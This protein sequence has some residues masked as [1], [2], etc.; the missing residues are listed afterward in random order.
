MNMERFNPET[1]INTQAEK[2]LRKEAVRI[3][4]NDPLSSSTETPKSIDQ[5]P[6]ETWVDSLNPD[7]IQLR[8][9]SQLGRSSLGGFELELIKIYGVDSNNSLEHKHKLRDAWL[10]AISEGVEQIE[11][12]IT[13]KNQERAD[14]LTQEFLINFPTYSNLPS[15]LEHLKTGAISDRDL[16]EATEL[17]Q[18]NLAHIEQKFR[19]YA[20]IIKTKFSNAVA[21]AVES[22]ILPRQAN[23]NLSRIENVTVQIIDRIEKSGSK[24]VGASTHD[25]TIGAQSSYIYTFDENKPN[26]ELDSTIFHELVHTIAG[27][28]LQRINTPSALSRKLAV[29]FKRVKTGVDINEQNLWLNEALTQY[30]AQIL[31]NISQGAPDTSIDQLLDDEDSYAR[32]QLKLH[33]LI[34][35]GVSLETLLNAYFENF[36]PADK[37]FEGHPPAL[38]VLKKEIENIEG[39]DSMMRFNNMFTFN[40]IYSNIVYPTGK[41]NHIFLLQDSI[42]KADVRLS[43]WLGLRGDGLKFIRVDV[44]IGETANEAATESFLYV[45]DTDTDKFDIDKAIADTKTDIEESLNQYKPKNHAKKLTYSIKTHLSDDPSD[46]N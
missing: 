8:R 39:A 2:P 6:T 5:T 16:I 35:K 33:E 11:G 19:D 37:T 29:R 17:H 20:E 21:V 30:I 46:K 22:G 9:E 26:Q 4:L 7:I 32:E 42:D 14:I 41:K 40:D 12:F 15:L 43:N 44:S 1:E 13:A 25:G 36:I 10:K 31:S 28:I 38:E 3:R 45:H 23:Q 34:T 27:E 18:K 24:T